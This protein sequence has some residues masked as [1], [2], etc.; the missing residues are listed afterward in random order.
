MSDEEAAIYPQTDD[1]E[2]P[3]IDDLES[4]NHSPPQ[5]QEE[6]VRPSGG[7]HETHLLSD[8]EKDSWE[9]VD[10]HVPDHDHDDHIDNSTQR[11]SK[12]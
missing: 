6:A 8:E 4:D 11:P 7:D 5:P 1:H 3:L 10:S 2:T 12:Q 9:P